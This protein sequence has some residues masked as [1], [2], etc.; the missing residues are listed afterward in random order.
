M[1]A[2]KE[3]TLQQLVDSA[4][5]AQSVIEDTEAELKVIKDELRDRLVQMKIQGTKVGEYLISRRKLITFPDVLMSQALELGATLV[6]IDNNKLRSL[7]DKGIQ[8][9]A[10]ITEFVTIKFI[11]EK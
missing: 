10:K 11:E 8:L 5:K 3:I 4:V 7:Y 6:K 9:K 1:E 2:I